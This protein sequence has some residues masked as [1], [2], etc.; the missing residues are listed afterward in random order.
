MNFFSRRKLTVA[1]TLLALTVLAG[2]W[3][4]SVRAKSRPTPDQSG[5]LAQAVREYVVDRDTDGDSLMDWEED[6]WKTNKNS[7]DTDGDGTGDNDEVRAGRNPTVAGPDD[8][9]AK[10]A[11]SAA[12]SAEEKNLTTTDIL[13]RNI[14]AEYYTLK[15]SGAL[16]E[17]AQENLILKNLSGALPG[18]HNVPTYGIDDI[19][20]R[21][22]GAGA[23]RAYGNAVG[24]IISKHSIET[25]NEGAIVER[26]LQ[27]DN[28][29][30]LAQVAAAAAAYRAI[31]Q[32]LIA[33]ET[34]LGA[35]AA[36]ISLVNAVTAL[37]EADAKLAI[38]LTDPVIGLIG[39]R[40]Y[41]QA[42]RDLYSALKKVGAVLTE[43]NVVFSSTEAGRSLQSIISQL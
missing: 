42:V 35:A 13:A 26:A 43:N 36:H 24:S 10:P 27:T 31:A 23:V 4:L 7:V 16:D 5:A 11:A 6:L 2:V 37:A 38:V 20:V 21:G 12:V 39:L 29:D 19:S 18:E 3:Y 8:T 17:A 32:G 30:E 15:Q 22:D 1:L 41:D 14:F 25:E 9:F 34:P 33:I 28:G 40:E